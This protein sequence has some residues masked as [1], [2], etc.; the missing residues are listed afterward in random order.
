MLD[1]PAKTPVPDFLPTG[2]M[3]FSI[4]PLPQGLCFPQVFN[5]GLLVMFG[6]LLS[7]GRHRALSV[8]RLVGWVNAGRPWR[9]DSGS[10]SIELE[11]CG[12]QSRYSEP[13]GE[14]WW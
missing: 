5:G 14:P 10:F 12:R 9:S 7:L 13:V 3:I 11:R 4:N 8:W 2:S 6:H 1:W